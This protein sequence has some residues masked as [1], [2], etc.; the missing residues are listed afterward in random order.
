M[1]HFS[2][3]VIGDN[4]VEQLAGYDEN[5]E[6]ETF[7]EGGQTYSR[8]P[9]A[10]WDWY[11][12]GGRWAGFFKLKPNASGQLGEVGDLTK[13]AEEGTADIVLKG[14]IDFAAMRAKAEARANQTYDLLEATLA[15]FKFG[16]SEVPSFKD[17]L[18]EVGGAE[19][20]ENIDKARQLYWS[21][22]IIKALNGAGLMSWAGS[23]QERFAGGRDAYVK[24]QGDASLAPFAILKNGEWF[25]QG[26]MG[27]WAIVSNEKDQ[28]D[29][30]AEVATMIEALSDDT[31]ITIVDCHI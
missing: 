15:P 25:G 16:L 4:V 3:F 28:D 11:M 19:K 18:L 5:L 23:I 20:R 17:I 14:D 21:Q 1:S 13:P 2:V 9:E 30:N 12:I 31:L 6:V 7:E 24:R 10:K 29:W 22:P 27:W 26:Q 8:N